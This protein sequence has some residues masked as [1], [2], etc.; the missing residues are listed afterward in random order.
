MSAPEGV[1]ITAFLVVTKASF[2]AREASAGVAV[3][4]NEVRISR[5]RGVA[6]KVPDLEAV[7]EANHHYRCHDAEAPSG[8]HLPGIELPQDLL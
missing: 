7:L 6:N 8:V 3:Y 4:A 5:G 1:G 2:E